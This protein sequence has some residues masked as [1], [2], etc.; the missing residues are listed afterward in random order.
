MLNLFRS[1]EHVRRWSLL[2]PAA[3]EAILPVRNWVR[4]F[5]VDYCRARLEPD[6]FL[7]AWELRPALFEAI[8]RQGKRG[9]FW[10]TGAT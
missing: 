9:P 1:E 2:D 5:S 7:R 3:A 8:A 4:V 10:G 6:Y